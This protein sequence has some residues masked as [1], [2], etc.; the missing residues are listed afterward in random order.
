M[1]RALFTVFFIS[2][3]LCMN[4][5]SQQLRKT[6][7]FFSD[8]TATI[9]SENENFNDKNQFTFEL[10]LKRGDLVEISIVPSWHNSDIATESQPIGFFGM[11][12]NESSVSGQQSC[13][14][15]ARFRL[16]RTFNELNEKIVGTHYLRVDDCAMHRRHRWYPLSGL[17]F[18]DKAE[19][20]RKVKYHLQV[21]SDDNTATYAYVKNA[22]FLIKVFRLAANT[23]SPT[24]TF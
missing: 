12:I 24:G 14:G 10:K 7:V 8:Q 5:S 16:L 21:A 18:F 15:S 23:E 1:R 9:Q 17:Q 19:L 20:S 11:S 6:L 13:G 3:I 4:L 22:R 2:V